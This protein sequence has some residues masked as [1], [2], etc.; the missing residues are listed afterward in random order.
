[1]MNKG[2][3]IVYFY[4]CLHIFTHHFYVSKTKGCMK[5]LK[6]SLSSLPVVPCLARDALAPLLTPSPG[7][8]TR[9]PRRL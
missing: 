9:A 1:M 8:A 2:Y 7:R 5:G 4:K 3:Q 6:F